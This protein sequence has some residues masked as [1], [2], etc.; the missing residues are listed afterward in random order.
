MSAPLLRLYHSMLRIRRIEE[1]V[2]DRYADQEMRCPTHLCIGQEAVPAGVCEALK[3]QDVVYSNHRAHGHYLAKGGDLNAF[4]AE[5]YGKATGCAGG[6]RG[7]MHLI[8]TRVGF[9]GCT[10]IVGGTVPLAMGAA[11]AAQLRRSGSVAV[12]FFGDG[13]FE[14]GVMHEC[15]NF[16][17]L[18]KLPLLFVCENN[19]YS[20]FTQLKER[21]PDRAIHAVVRSHGWKTGHGDGND[22]AQVFEMASAALADTRSGSGPHFLEFETFRWREHCGPNYD[23][24]LSYRSE[25]ELKNWKARCP[26]LHLKKTL[27]SE[28]L[29]SA[30]DFQR[31]EHEIQAEIKKAFDFA[32]SSPAPRVE[33]LEPQLYAD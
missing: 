29:C 22:A 18:K 28:K 23:D 4:I 21:Q 11:W 9:L 27:E 20:V 32:L 14:E 19:N 13:C 7:S 6:Y 24:H 16:A 8:D 17:A 31:M 26:V 12:A 15:L 10:P 1:A 33:T 5:L 25:E 2:A 30:A 3:K